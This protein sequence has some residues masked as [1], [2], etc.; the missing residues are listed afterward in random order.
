MSELVD[1]LHRGMSSWAIDDPAIAVRP[2]SLSARTVTAAQAALVG[3]SHGWRR[4]L[5]FAGPAIVADP[6]AVLAWSQVVLSLALPLPMVALVMF[7]GRTEIM[8][9]FANR[10]PTQTAAVA[11]AVIVLA[12]NAFL[13]LQTF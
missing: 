3:R 6:T 10:R 11:G 13:V 9:G 7:T 5:A 1:V 4:H 2:G 12:L 8:R